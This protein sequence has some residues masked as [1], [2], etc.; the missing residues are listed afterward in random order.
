ML[1]NYLVS[2]KNFIREFLLYLFRVL[3]DVA[4]L[5][6][7][8]VLFAQLKLFRLPQEKY[9]QGMAWLGERHRSSWE[10]W[11]NTPQKMRWAVWVA[12]CVLLLLV[13]FAVSGTPARQGAVTQK[14]EKAPLLAVL[15]EVRFF[16]AA[17]SADFVELKGVADGSLKGFALKNEK[18]ERYDLPDAALKKD[19]YLLISLDGKNQAFL[20]DV[21]GSLTLLDASGKLVDEVVWGSRA[22][23]VRISYG[24]VEEGASA[25]I[26]IG[27]IPGAVRKNSLEWVSFSG[28]EVTPG[29]ANPYPRVQVLLPIEGAVF[30]AS[31]EML[32]SWYPVAGATEYQVE[33]SKSE[34]FDA[35]AAKGTVKTPEFKARLPE[36]DYFWRVK[37]CGAGGCA[38]FSPLSS[39]TLSSAALP[40]PKGKKSSSL[41]NSAHAADTVPPLAEHVLDVPMISQHKDTRMLLLEEEDPARWDNDHGELNRNDPADNMNCGLASAQMVNHFFGGNVSQDRLGYEIFKDKDP[42]PQWD[43][44]YGNGVTED[45]ETRVLQFAVGNVTHKNI[46][47]KDAFWQD[48]TQSLDAGRPV[49]LNVPHHLVVIPGYYKL[50]PSADYPDSRWITANDPWNGRMLVNVG[51]MGTPWGYWTLNDMS[52][53]SSD[54]PAISQDS[55]DDGIV[56]FDESERMGTKVDNDDSDGDKIKDKEEL[57]GSVYDPDQGYTAAGGFGWDYDGDDKNMALDDNSDGGSCKD[58]DEDTNLNGWHDGGESSNFNADDDKCGK[59]KPLGGYVKISYVYS[60][61]RAA[62]CRG[63]AEIKAWF[64]LQPMENKAN[65]TSPVALLY[66]ATQMTYDVRTDGCHN[67]LGHRV[68]NAGEVVSEGTAIHLS[69]ATPLTRENLGSVLFFSTYP[70]LSMS[71]PLLIHQAAKFDET[72][73]YPDGFVTK[74][75]GISLPI[76]ALSLDDTLSCGARA[77]RASDPAQWEFCPV[78]LTQCGSQMETPE[79]QVECVTHPEKHAIIPFGGITRWDAPADE[80]GNFSL[81]G[82]TAVEWNICEGCG[83][84]PK[85]MNGQ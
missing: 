48:V 38:G 15:N 35:L 13:W 72:T 64:D 14:K 36:G 47:T 30:P 61:F 73:T 62:N 24:G 82:D 40:F 26:S 4:L 25:G 55:D 32:F 50:S 54:E 9:D 45:E 43:L 39:F 51:R 21:S 20:S 3:K 59:P 16:S 37:A 23:A 83:E 46:T 8:A 85:N 63:N 19:E 6:R 29:K 2:I 80:P 41:L 31:E 68:T 56:D 7:G 84:V 1:M 10:D 5:V 60:D 22:G 67:V 17:G 79:V 71:L 75:D 76:E 42:G 53:V 33:V 28:E 52:H 49:I 74:Q 57:Y 65:P 70:K 69:G 27:R 34:S 58:N 78:S 11:K 44:N 81:I 77:S 66:R 18:G 12:F